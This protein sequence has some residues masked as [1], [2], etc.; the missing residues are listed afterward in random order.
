M[1]AGNM[2][3]NTAD[4]CAFHT[5][6]CQNRRGAQRQN[7]NNNKQSRFAHQISPDVV[8]VRDRNAA[9]PA[10]DARLQLTT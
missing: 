5:T 3:G 10:L 1:A 2:P 4:R 6:R 9:G 7:G 8:S